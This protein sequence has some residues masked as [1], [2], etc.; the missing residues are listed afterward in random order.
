MRPG[1]AA[2]TRNS[3]PDFSPARLSAATGIVAWFFALILV[4]PRTRLAFTFTDFM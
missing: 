3:S 1:P 2:S 4:C